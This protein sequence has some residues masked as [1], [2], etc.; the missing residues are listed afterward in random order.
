MSNI[1][2]DFILNTLKEY[3]SNI[4][5]AEIINEIPTS[6]IEDL[7]NGNI[8]YSDLELGEEKENSQYQGYTKEQIINNFNSIF[9]NNE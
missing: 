6:I 4:D 3:H 7:L 5:N 8:D 1:I 9:N 2:R